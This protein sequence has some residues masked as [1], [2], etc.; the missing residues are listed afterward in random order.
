MI[1]RKRKR[2]CIPESQSSTFTQCYLSSSSEGWSSQN[3]VAD[4]VHSSAFS[5][6]SS[7]S[8]FE[9]RGILAERK[10]EY[11]IDWAND[12]VTGEPF[13]PDWVSTLVLE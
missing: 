12:P 7:G 6:Q 2:D 11:L 13:D 4:S 5:A 3:S 10:D 9:I 1:V 8:V